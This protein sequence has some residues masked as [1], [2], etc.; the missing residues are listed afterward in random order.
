MKTLALL[1]LLAVLP[2]C[3]PVGL[4]DQAGLSRPVFQFTASGPRALEGSLSTQLETGRGTSSNVS[5]GG[6]SSCR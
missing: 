3:R 2:A 5:A 6:C 1:S 4:A